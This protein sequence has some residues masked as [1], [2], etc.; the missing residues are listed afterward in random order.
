M[1][2][3]KSKL[4][5]PNTGILQQILEEGE[6]A[7]AF[8]QIGFNSK[9]LTTKR[10]IF[11][12]TSEDKVKESINL[13]DIQEFLFSSKMGAP[14]LEALMKDGSKQKIGSLDKSVEAEVKEIFI[15]SLKGVFRIE[16]NVNDESAPES[17]TSSTS[18]EKASPVRTN[19]N[20]EFPKW[21]KKS[22]ENA[23]SENEDLLMVITEP[24]VNHQ[25]ALLV[26]GNRCV[27]TKGGLVGG[28]MA[29]SL[30]GERSATFFFSQ[31]T[32]IEY[33]SGMING[34]LEILTPSYDGSRNKDFWQGSTS[35]RN[36]NSNDPWTLSNTL[37]LT[38]NG[39]KTAKGMIDELRLMVA[40]AHQPKAAK[41]ESAP[42]M[43]GELGE[44]SKLYESG[45]LT[46]EE[47]LAA[48][49]KILGN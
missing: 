10:L 20:R 32:G 42:S 22:I 16:E 38:K 29:G 30:G 21:L 35:S 27:L 45:L 28:F 46:D 12:N 24:D 26:F 5:H 40:E 19:S 1:Y 48:K 15:N 37:P 6:Q 43:A 7:V 9:V 3:Q 41:V 36:A 11:L 23:K 2:I 13:D 14:S 8:L 31:I 39:Y 25:G 44:L 34:V 49:R 4:Y 18:S 17:S 47:F 33:N